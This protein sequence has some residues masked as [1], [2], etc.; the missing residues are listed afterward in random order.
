MAEEWT[1]PVKAIIRRDKLSERT[2]VAVF[3][4][5]FADTDGT[6]MV[7]YYYR[8]DSVR[9]VIGQHDSCLYRLILTNTK[10]VSFEDPYVQGFIKH[11][12][13]DIGY[14]FDFVSRASEKMNRIRREHA[15]C[16]A[17][18]VRHTS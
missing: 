7:C 4:E 2:L 10:P 16:F 15:R 5:L 17:N 9:Q 8:C 18:E 1:K 12:T 13:E 6:H 11:L 3:P 14:E